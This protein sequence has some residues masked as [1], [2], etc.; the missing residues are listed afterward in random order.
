MNNETPEQREKR[1]KRNRQNYWNG[2]RDRKIFRKLTLIMAMGGKCQYC[3]YGRN[4]AALDFH[5]IDQHDKIHNMSHLLTSD[6]P[7][8]F[9]IAKRESEKCELVCSNCH[10]ELTFAGH[11]LYALPR[12]EVNF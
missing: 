7:E 11:E 1:I 8:N 12:A 4:A 2:A 3:G 9:E 10:R 5:H 6:K